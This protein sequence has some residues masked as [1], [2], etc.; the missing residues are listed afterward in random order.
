MLL[1]FWKKRFQHSSVPYRALLT[2]GISLPTLLFSQTTESYPGLFQTIEKLIQIDERDYNELQKKIQTHSITLEQLKKLKDVTLDP[3]FL[4]SILFHTH[5]SFLDLSYEKDCQFYSFLENKLLTRPYFITRSIPIR[6][7]GPSGQRLSTLIPSK[8]FFTFIY[9][10]KCKR[11]NDI[12]LIFKKD[13]LKKTLT[14]LKFPIPTNQ[15]GCFAILKNWQ[16]NESIGPLCRIG[17]TLSLLPQKEKQ[18]SGIAR[19]QINLRRQL[20][21]EITQGVFLKKHLSSFQAD[22]LAHLCTH[23]GTHPQ[24]RKRFCQKFLTTSFWKKVAQNRIERMELTVKCQALLNKNKLSFQELKDCAKKLTQNKKTCHYLETD[25]YQ[26]LIPMPDCHRL[27]EALSISRLNAKYQDCPGKVDNEGIINFGRILSHLNN[28]KE[29]MNPNNCNNISISS[30]VDLNFDNKNKNAWK[31]R[32]CYPD[33]IENKELCLPAIIGQSE[34][35]NYSENKI[36]SHILRR[37]KSA[38]K[39]LQCMFVEQESYNPKRLKYQDGCFL[40]YNKNDCTSLSCPKKIVFRDQ[41]VKNITYRGTGSFD[42]FPNS[43]KDEQKA[44]THILEKVRKVRRKAIRNITDLK[45][46]LEL[47]PNSL[48]HGRGCI[49]DI[50]PRNFNKRYMN[51]CTPVS[52][53]ID[54]LIEKNFKFYL[55]IRTGADS[56]HA[57]R[58]VRW[59][60]IYNA[61]TSYQGFWP[62]DHWTLYGIR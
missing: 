30:F 45:Y 5:L 16:K 51:H 49:E 55:T 52:F 1:K 23:L 6:Y 20:Q 27:S 18:F 36:V 48:I 46:Y 54:G 19:S 62:F 61:I 32:I 24:N 15:T 22:Y 8:D 29:E 33:P 59:H 9:G 7:R 38:P 10:Q 34:T 13:H 3:L 60:N 39:S 57:P 35:S 25:Q 53:I 31:F 2:L 42:Y 50:Y 21:N 26:A 43:L 17:K 40:I 11:N 4:K 37:I 28:R 58:I 41:D 56:V 14:T 44:V 47:S 12:N